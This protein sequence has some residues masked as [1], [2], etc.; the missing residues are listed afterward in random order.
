MSCG[1]GCRLSSDPMLLWLWRRPAA[2]ALMRPLA[3]ESAYATGAALEK[4]KRHTHTKPASSWI[5][6]CNPL[7][8]NGNSRSYFFRIPP[9]LKKICLRSSFVAYWVKD[10]VLPQLHCRLQH[11]C[12]WI[13]VP[14]TSTCCRWGQKIPPSTKTKIKPNQTKPNQNRS[15]CCGPA[16]MNLTSIHEV[17]SL[18]S[19]SGLRIWHCREL[20]CRPAA[21]TP[22]WLLAWEPPYGSGVAL[23]QKQNKILKIYL[24]FIEAIVSFI[25]LRILIKVSSFV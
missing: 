6:V 25:S 1:V 8:H 20:W 21:T 2:T 4:T 23:K 5:L 9:T 10:P 16:E 11:Q 12:H 13:P 22:I 24:Y 17:Q 18:A 7:S 3:W 15:S 19:L 14:G